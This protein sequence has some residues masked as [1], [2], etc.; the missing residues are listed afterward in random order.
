MTA[1]AEAAVQ[2]VDLPNESHMH[3]WRLLTL[4]VEKTVLNML[5][6]LWKIVFMWH[7]VYKVTFHGT[8]IHFL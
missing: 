5:W 8:F 2:I 7:C 3:Y 6:I 1:G 4:A